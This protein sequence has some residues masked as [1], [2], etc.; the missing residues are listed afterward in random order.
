MQKMKINKIL[1]IFL[2][3]IA[4]SSFGQVTKLQYSD[5]SL[6][7]I[8][9]MTGNRVGISFYNDGAIA[10]FNQGIDI[11]GEWPLGSG[12][13]Y[14]G[15]LT[16]LIG[17]EAIANGKL[18]HSVGISRGP[19]PGQYDEKDPVNGSYWGFNPVPGFRNPQFQSVALSDEPKSWPKE[20]WA[21]QPTWKDE[22]GNTQWNGYFGR[23]VINADLESYYVADDHWD[24]EFNQKFGFV[25]NTSDTTRKG[26]GMQMFVRGFQ[27]N[28]VLAQD[29]IFW[30]YKIKNDGTYSYRKAAF[31]TVVGTLAGGDGDSIDDLGFFDPQDWVTYSW[32]ADNKGNKGQKVGYVGYAYLES[33]GNAYNGIDDDDDC[34]NPNIQRFKANDWDTTKV[35]N[36][37]D[38]VVLIDSL[39]NRS[40]SEV[41]PGVNVFTTLG[42]QITVIPGITKRCEG[43]IIGYL[44]PGQ[45][46]LKKFPTFGAVA[47]LD[48]SAYDGI[49]NDLDGLIDEN[50]SL[51][52]LARV[53]YQAPDGTT[54]P[55]PALKRIDYFQLLTTN[56]YT[57]Y[58]DPLIDEK[59]D[60]EAGNLISS[61]V[62]D[63]KGN[64]IFKQH[65]AGDDDGD[66]NPVTDDVGSD[67]IGKYDDGY[68]GPDAD[69]SEGNGKPDQG[70]PNF[71]KTDPHE[72]DQIG[73]TGFNFFAQSASPK[74]NQDEELW[75]RM[76]PGR[77]DIIPS[78]PQDGDFIYS[79]GYFPLLPGKEETFSVAILFGE[80]YDAVI[81]MKKSVQE[82]YNFGYTFAKPPT[83]PRINITQEN[84]KVILY[85]DPE[86]S[87]NSID[88]MTKEK[89]FQGF[90][91]FR[92]SDPDFRDSRIITNAF[93]SLVDDKPIAQYDLN[94]T[95]D[96]F[97]KAPYD[98]VNALGGYNF[99]LGKNT[100]IV[101]KY[102]DS[103]VTPGVTYY[104]AV[105]AYD[106]GYPEKKI[107]PSINS[108]NILVTPTGEIVAK[109]GNTA[110]ITP[111]KD[112]AGFQRGSVELQKSNPFVGTGAVYVN[113]VDNKKILDN[114]KYKIV[115]QDT[116][117]VSKTSNWSL[118]KIKSN[119]QVD[120]L[121]KNSG[122]FYSPSKIYDGITVS[123]LP[124]KV[125]VDTNSTVIDMPGNTPKVQIQ[126]Y[127]DNEAKYNG[128][129]NP[130][131][132]QF[133]FSTELTQSIPDT[134]SGGEVP[135][136]QAPFKVKNLTSGKYIDFV[137]Y[138]NDGLISTKH[139]IWFKEY[140]KGKYVRTWYIILT[141]D[142]NQGAPTVQLP[143]S[144][145]ISF[146]TKKPFIESDTLYFTTIAPKIDNN[147]AKS[148]LDLIKV[149]PNP[150]VV[151]HEAEPKLSSFVTSGRGERFI[152]FTHVPY[153]AKISIFTV[154]G[155]LVKTLYQDDMYNG[156]VKWNLRTD[157]NLDAAFGV[158]IYVV[159]AKGIGTK[160]GKFALIK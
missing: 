13:N 148:E 51:H 44:W 73:L 48:S 84:G 150:Y 99:Y 95:I 157:E 76:E 154:R 141:Y 1:I 72:S 88:V 57:T 100:G 123:V 18:F 10:G 158:Y 147:K 25:P 146:K 54:K 156:D 139:I 36:V 153:Q 82:I 121:I 85:W 28:N 50:Q 32:D 71:G 119:N 42:K 47:V 78:K 89:D 21:D 129:P 41:Q 3:F 111:A 130:A 138:I 34:V 118:L 77:F 145:K 66:W 9:Y 75:T 60:N 97:F 40:L 102:I 38:K 52:Y 159:E 160:T 133:E 87:M 33:P 16:P 35:F 131:N 117:I 20:G 126:V 63:A 86:L 91:I 37:G 58:W 64:V 107:F 56:N 62:T 134:I 14:I 23:G 113:V 26:M 105:C 27:W 114:Q 136:S 137:Y 65:Y 69:G 55:K 80:D 43:K 110:Y 92:S 79:S 96:G 108:K 5:P 29:V 143:T 142:K 103:S 2:A 120:T 144:G 8:G 155:E 46:G 7:T 53:N 49:D 11:R 31:G 140:L 67:G 19:R 106:K 115:F 94:D 151:T 83:A 112:V 152:R 149:V 98:L 6:Y 45:T 39:Y 30:L 22:K 101:N 127:E 70:E 68:T 61:W 93:G 17:L 122:D 116:G 104:Y 135:S 4:S 132:Y 128:Y 74:M 12:Y 15:D 24:R 124:D 125:E 90:K 81:R 109:G 59:R